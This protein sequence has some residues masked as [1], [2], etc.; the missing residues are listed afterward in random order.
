[1]R[2]HVKE[3]ILKFIPDDSGRSAYID[4]YGTR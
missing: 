3:Y 4:R 1:M 2:R